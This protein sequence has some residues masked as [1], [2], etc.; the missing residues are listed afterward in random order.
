MT[1]SNSGSHRG[2]RARS[3]L[4]IRWVVGSNPPWGVSDIY[5]TETR[6]RISSVY[7]SSSFGC[8]SSEASDGETKIKRITTFVENKSRLQ[9]QVPAVDIW[10]QV[11]LL[12]FRSVKWFHSIVRCFESFHEISKAICFRIVIKSLAIS[13]N[14]WTDLLS[15]EVNHLL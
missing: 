13:F 5:S 10:F 11:N 3:Q 12:Y 6:S 7:I 9:S 2:S 15:R 4:S 1:N 8:V 14:K